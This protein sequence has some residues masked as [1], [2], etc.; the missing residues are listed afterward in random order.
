MFQ[1]LNPGPASGVRLDFEGESITAEAGETVAAALLAAGIGRFRDTPVEGRP[2]APY[3]MMGICFDCLVEI[4]GVPNRQA[5]MVPVADG[6][7]IRRQHG[8]R[9]AA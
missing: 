2:R 4:D 6:M 3:C 7:K 9:D 5:C 8:A 1:R